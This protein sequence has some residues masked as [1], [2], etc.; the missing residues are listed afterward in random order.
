MSTSNPSYTTREL[1]HQFVDSN[2]K[3][4]ITTPSLYSKL[5][6][7]VR[8]KNIKVFILGDTSDI[9]DAISYDSLLSSGDDLDVYFIY[10]LLFIPNN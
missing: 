9:P 2:A 7:I 6:Q 3:Y 4:L 5:E 8:V 10:A 1:E